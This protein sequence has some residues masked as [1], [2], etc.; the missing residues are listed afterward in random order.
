MAKKNPVFPVAL[1]LTLFFGVIYFSKK[2]T[3]DSEQTFLNLLSNSKVTT[4]KVLDSEFSNWAPSGW[5]VRYKFSLEGNPY[6]EGSCKGLC[7]WYKPLRP[8]DEIKIIYEIENPAN[9]CEIRSFLSDPS[10]RHY[11]KNNFKIKTFDDLG[12]KY[13]V[14]TYSFENWYGEMRRTACNN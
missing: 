7:M 2:T 4:A 3:P 9:N 14:D 13:D 8:G 11:A 12:T 1:G 10:H 5:G 6:V